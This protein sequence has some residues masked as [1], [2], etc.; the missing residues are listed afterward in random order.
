MFSGLGDSGHGL[1]DHRVVRSLCDGAREAW[2]TVGVCPDRD[3]RVG[4]HGDESVV[5]VNLV[6][7]LSWTTGLGGTFSGLDSVVFEYS[8]VGSEIVETPDDASS[9]LSSVGQGIPDT[10]AI[11]GLAG[12]LSTIVEPPPP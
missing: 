3:G 12:I 4:R 9:G 11:N 6:E 8:A 7:F 5:L 2:S 1:L 10:T